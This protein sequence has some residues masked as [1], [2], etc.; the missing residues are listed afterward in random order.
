VAGEPILTGVCEN[1]FWRT[2]SIARRI[3][4]GWRGA[5]GAVR[6]LLTS[7][8]R[9]SRCDLKEN[10]TKLRRAGIFEFVGHSRG[11]PEQNGTLSPR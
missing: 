4:G 7:P 2:P 9:G 5:D 10:K 11:D 8:W 1:E 6:L 3:W